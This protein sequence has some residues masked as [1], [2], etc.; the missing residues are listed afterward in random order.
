MSDSIQK[1]IQ[2]ALMARLA[3]DVTTPAPAGI[4]TSTV[5]KN[6]TTQI[7]PR[8]LPTYSVYFVKGADPDLIGQRYA[9]VRTDRSD[10]IAVRVVVHGDD[11][12]LEPHKKWVTNRMASAGRIPVDDLSQGLA[13]GV[14]E[15]GYT[16]QPAE[17]S[18]GK[19]LEWTSHWVVEFTTLPADITQTGRN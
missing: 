1:R 15:A 6:R 17:G 9:P 10:L 18:D 19:I 14:I 11:D 5:T 13:K 7:D 2:D 8:F 16:L 4:N 12:T 3:G